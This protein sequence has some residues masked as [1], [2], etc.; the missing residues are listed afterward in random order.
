VPPL[1]LRRFPGQVAL[2]VAEPEASARSL[3]LLLGLREIPYLYS[4]DNLW[5]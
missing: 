1:V 3:L 2:A 5:P 4:G